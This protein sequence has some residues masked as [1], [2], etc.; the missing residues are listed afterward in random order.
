[1]EV[2]WCVT[3]QAPAL[4][5][6]EAAR[7][8]ARHGFRALKVKGGQ[9][10]PTDI[11][12]LRDIRAAVGDAV[13]FTVDANGA[14]PPEQAAGYVRAI[15]DAGATIAEDPCRLQPDAAFAA[16][17]RDSPIPILVDGP[18]ASLRDA[19]L[20]LDR[21]ARALSV[22]PARI[23]I[24]EVRRIVALARERGANVCSGMYAESAL[25]TLI[26]L[27][28]SAALH[29]PLVA[30]EQSFFLMMTAQVLAT[31]PRIVGGRIALPDH[32]DQAALVDWDSVARHAL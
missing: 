27:Q 28:L 23:G 10:L 13:A 1:V 15:A 31:P 9:G 24:S 22:K 26:S 14:Y 25:G 20:F 18:C 12:A 7:M 30:A 29:A 4:M 5:A 2:S 8:V 3:R 6:A 32:A 21:G 19:T 11:Q 17:M 16:L